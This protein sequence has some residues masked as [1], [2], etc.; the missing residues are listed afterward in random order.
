M[1]HTTLGLLLITFSAS[2]YAQPIDVK[3]TKE[4]SL[5]TQGSAAKILSYQRRSK[6]PDGKYER[7]NYVHPLYD[8]DGNLLTEDFPEDHPHHRCTFWAWHHVLVNGKQAG[9]PWAVRDFAAQVQDA[10]VTSADANSAAM[11]VQVIR[12]SRAVTDDA[13]AMLPLVKEMTTLR[14]HRAEANARNID[15]DI[16]RQLD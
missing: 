15:F 11:D 8:L 13:D 10:K 2:L 9:V 1:K 4:G 14:V 12:K 3:A 5:F 6:S 16:H 7:A